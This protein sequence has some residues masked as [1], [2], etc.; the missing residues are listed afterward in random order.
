MLIKFEDYSNYYHLNEWTINGAVDQSALKKIR[1]AMVIVMTNFGFFSD[2]LFNLRMKEMVNKKEVETM[3]TDGRNIYYNPHF[4]KKLDVKQVVFV[5]CHEIMHN[6]MLHFYRQMSRNGELWNIA[7]DY[8]INI[9]LNEMRS[10]NILTNPVKILLD[11]KYKN[12]S[13]EQIYEELIEEH[14]PKKGQGGGG[15]Q[16]Q[17]GS[18]SGSGKPKPGQGSGSGQGRMPTPEEM[19]DIIDA[20]K[21]GAGLD[22]D[23]A[24]TANDILQ[25]GQLGNEG[26]DAFTPE[27]GEAA[28]NEVLQGTLDAGELAKVWGDLRRMA[29]S[30]HISGKGS[31]GLDRF[32]K[33]L[34]KPKIN[35]KIELKRFVATVFNR[36]EYAL[37]NKKYVSRGQYLN[38]LKKVGRG[39]YQDVVVAIDTSGSIGET[40]LNTFAVELL[41]L[42]KEFSIE[43]C[44]IVWCDDAITNIQKFT[45][46]RTKPLNIA[47]LRPKGYGGTSFI[48]PFKWIRGDKDTP[49]NSNCPLEARKLVFPKGKNPAFMIYFTDG[50]HSPVPT[51]FLISKI[52]SRVMWVIKGKD[53]ADFITFGKKIFVDT[54]E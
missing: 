2:L 32:I 41:K 23:G 16:G 22:Q 42:F 13:V 24:L 43:N 44:Y 34:I 36:W 10:D 29:G 30:R 18:G 51:G 6:T 49:F 31:A 52:K 11:E 12:M 21:K 38:T 48:P 17:G 7:G 5:L 50:D 40:E 33:D 28:G 8:S 45:I 14:R 15:G 25:P 1:E 19:K 20:I 47:K 26:E 54:I 9:I 35:W 46:D 53:K 3:A 39:D 27:A 37:P 4:V